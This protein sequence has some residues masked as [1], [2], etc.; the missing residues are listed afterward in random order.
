MQNEKAKKRGNK[1]L[2]HGP[3]VELD[4]KID[5]AN[6]YGTGL[7]AYLYVGT[8][9]QKVIIAFDT[10]SDWTTFETDLCPNCISPFFATKTS[11]TYKN[12]SSTIYS[13][14]YNGL[15]LKGV[16]GQD[17]VGLLSTGTFTTANFKFFAMTSQTG[18]TS[19]YD[20]ILGLSR[21]YYSVNF[22]T[23]PL[24]NQQLKNTSMITQDVFSLYVSPSISYINFGAPNSSAI[25]SG[26]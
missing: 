2:A 20:G 5:V 18:M 24:F 3:A 10:G 26:S 14:S 19:V 22:T 15:S 11:T 16:V 25:K 6:Y 12:V 1:K 17:N 23:G 21:P 8:P 9:V 4:T 13:L 7:L